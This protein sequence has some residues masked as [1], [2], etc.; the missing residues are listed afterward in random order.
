M[1]LSAKILLCVSVPLLTSCQTEGRPSRSIIS[2]TSEAVWKEALCA[3]GKAI[4]ISRGD[5]LTLD[6]AEQINDHNASLFC[7]CPDKRPA[8]FDPAVCKV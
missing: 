7:A 1:R 3:T 8:K 5:V 6:T 2:A 4:L